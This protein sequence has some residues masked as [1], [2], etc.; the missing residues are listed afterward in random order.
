VVQ[1][2]GGRGGPRGHGVDRLLR[3]LGI[4]PGS[5]VTGYGLVVRAGGDFALEECGVL[6]ADASAPLPDRLAQIHHALLGLL[7]RLRPTCVSVEDVFQGRNARSAAVLGQA[8]GAI[9]LTV[10]LS[11]LE[12]AEYPPATIK[13]AVVGNGNADKEQVAFM[14]QKHLGLASPPEPADAAAGCAAA[15][16]HL[17]VGVGPLAR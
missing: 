9:L 17:M 14:V 8:R 4:D 13:K 1:L 10:A 2:R 6:R 5:Q 3:V 7:E 15:L 11:E 16:C 12:V